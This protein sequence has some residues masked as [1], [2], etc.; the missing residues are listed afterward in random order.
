MQSLVPFT[1]GGDTYTY[2]QAHCVKTQTPRWEGPVMTEAE[3]GLMCSKPRFAEDGQQP[4][5]AG[6]DQQGFSPP[7]F[8]GAWPCQHPDFWPPEL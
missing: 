3:T 1:R 6:R 8:G 4:P 7:G 2:T 5:G